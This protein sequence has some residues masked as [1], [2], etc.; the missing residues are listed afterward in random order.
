M[1]KCSNNNISFNIKTSEDL[2]S[3]IFEIILLII[4]FYGF[5]FSLYKQNNTKFEKNRMSSKL[6]MQIHSQATKLNAK[7][8]AALEN[9]GPY[10]PPWLLFKLL[11]SFFIYF[12]NFNIPLLKYYILIGGTQVI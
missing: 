7:I 6:K 8:I 9:V 11:S 10:I 5:Y 2:F 12:F 1:I 3:L 4:A